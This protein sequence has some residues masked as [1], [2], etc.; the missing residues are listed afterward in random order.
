MQSVDQ[1]RDLQQEFFILLFLWWVWF[2]CVN[3][4]SVFFSLLSITIF[5]QRDTYINISGLDNIWYIHKLYCIISHLSR[6]SLDW[7]QRDNV[8]FFFC[9]PIARIYSFNYFTVIQ[10]QE[11]SSLREF[12]ERSICW[13]G[14]YMT[15]TVRLIYLLDLSRTFK[16]K[17]DGLRIN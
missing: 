4:P 14:K 10:I 6:I 3:E 1:Y 5:F 16:E 12:R 15:F 13:N 2:Y 11:T 8:A 9:Y 17:M 7:K